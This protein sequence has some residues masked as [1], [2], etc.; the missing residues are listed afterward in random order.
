MK[1]FLYRSCTRDASP[2]LRWFFKS[3]FKVATHEFPLGCDF[4]RSFI[5]GVRCNDIIK[6]VGGRSRF[7]KNAGDRG[8]DRGR[9]ASLFEA[10]IHDHRSGWSRHLPRLWV[11][12]GLAAR[13][14]I[15][16]RR[17]FVGGCRIHRH[18]C[19]G[20]RQCPHRAGCLAIACRRA[21]HF[22]QGGR[23]HRAFG[24]WPRSAWR[25]GI[26]LYSHWA[27]RSCT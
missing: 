23:R 18:E 19:L 9:R 16:D 8:G 26:F 21:R 20:A 27:A 12:S 11:L 4:R 1:R 2:W 10:P 5:C 17:G 24:R 25:L 14:R 6:I 22:I 7:G 13:R 3:T 15:S